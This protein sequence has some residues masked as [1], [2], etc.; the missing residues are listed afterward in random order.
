M[1]VGGRVFNR[2]LVGA[3]DVRARRLPPPRPAPSTQIPTLAVVL[4]PTE[5]R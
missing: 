4:P 2:V 3:D 5:T 1:V